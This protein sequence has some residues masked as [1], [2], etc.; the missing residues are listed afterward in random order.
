MG[1]IIT[2]LLALLIFGYGGYQAYKTIKQGA[3]GKCQGC[4]CGDCESSDC[5]SSLGYIDFSD[6]EEDSEQCP[7]KN[8]QKD[9]RQKPTED[10]NAND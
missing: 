3:E 2:G 8:S 6:L 4:S 10:E 5:A 9:L 1:T 7:D